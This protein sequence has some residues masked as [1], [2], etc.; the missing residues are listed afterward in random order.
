MTNPG[1][2]GDGAALSVTDDPRARRYEARLGDELAGTAAYIRTPEVIAFIHT[3]VGDA[4]EG[5]GIGSALARTGLDDARAQG[6]RV[7][8]I[9][10]FIAGWLARHPEYDDLQFVP[11]SSVSD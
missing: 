3:E 11:E 4:Y 1:A 10:P 6:L 9:C 8:A 7:L 2:I 5:R